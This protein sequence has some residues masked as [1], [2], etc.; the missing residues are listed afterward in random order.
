MWLHVM[1]TKGVNLYMFV[2]ARAPTML[3]WA[4]SKVLWAPTTKV[5]NKITLTVF[6][7]HAGSVT[8][9]KGRGQSVT[10]TVFA[11]SLN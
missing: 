5:G 3:S 2:G 6:Y 7:A 10:T 4:P 8:R 9:T 11:A 1:I